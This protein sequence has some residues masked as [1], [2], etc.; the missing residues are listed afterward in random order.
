MAK[1]VIVIGGGAAGMLASL[2]AARAGARVTLIERNEKLGKKVYITG[3]GRCNVTNA[4]ER[5]EFMRHILRNPRFMYA[6][7]A[8]IDNFG[9]MELIESLGVPLKVERGERVFPQ[10]DRANDINRALE[11][12][13]NR[14]HV[15]IRLNT[16]V[17]SLMLDGGACTG[18]LTDR[19]EFRGDGIVVC[20]GG[21]SYPLTGSTGDGHAFARDLGLQ[22]TDLIP[23]LVPINTVEK[24]T[25]PLSG[26][27]L[28]NVALRAYNGKK[29]IF[30]EQ[31]EMLMTHFGISG[32]LVLTLSSLLPKDLSNVRLS[33]DLKPA[34]DDA[35]LDAR[36]VRELRENSR[37]SVSSIMDSLTPHNL[38]LT[39]L[40]LAGIA[41]NVPANAITHAQRAAIRTLLKEL[42]LTPMSLRGFD[43][44]I[45]T[46]GGVSVK[47]INPSTLESRKVSGLYFAGEVLDIDATT[48]GFNLQIAWSTGALAGLSAASLAQA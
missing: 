17:I 40:E 3:K 42:P 1:N 13:L 19:G 29:R 23:A 15:D 14:L 8:T 18:V 46:R 25:S 37:R 6:S 9:V 38:G 2:F 5:E 34:L 20:T 26:L 12:E 10:S 32:P 45:V 21:V 22:V 33:I 30:S 27:S 28:K 41:P 11:R 4:A 7:L 24:W 35:T 43:E 39:I 16:R 36:L 44:A 47:E 48:G 31:G